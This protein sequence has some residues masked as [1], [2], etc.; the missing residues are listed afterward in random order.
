MPVVFLA[1]ARGQPQPA[2]V[3]VDIAHLGSETRIRAVAGQQEQFQD[4][5]GWVASVEHG[6]YARACYLPG[7]TSCIE[8]AWGRIIG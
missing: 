7:I 1:L 2:G 4:E 5:G 8:Q 3:P 6:D